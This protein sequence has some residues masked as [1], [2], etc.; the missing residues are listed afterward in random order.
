MQDDVSTIILGDFNT[1]DINLLTLCT[2]SP[3]SRNLCNTLHH[4]NYLQLVNTLTHQ[5]GNILDLIL[6]NAPHR[7][8]NIAVSTD[9]TL[10]SDHFLVTADINF[11][12]SNTNSTRTVGTGCYVM[13]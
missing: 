10:N 8:S 1:P 13:L 5:A 7:I 4:L 12:H 3:V 2:G 6:M 11:S 9:S